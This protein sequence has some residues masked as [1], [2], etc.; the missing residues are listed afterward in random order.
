MGGV[1]NLSDALAWANTLV[2]AEFDNWRL[3]AAV[4]NPGGTGWV[5]YNMIGSELGHLYYTELGNAPALGGPAPPLNTGPFI[6]LHQDVF[7]SDGPGNPGGWMWAFNFSGGG[8]ALGYD[9]SEM[10]AWAVR[11]GDRSTLVSIDIK[12]GTSPN[13]INLGSNGSVAVAI[14]T[15]AEF[16]A[17]MVDP[18]TVEFADA[19]PFKRRMV[20]VDHDGNVDMLLY[21]YIQELNLDL[22]SILAT[23]TGMTDDDRVIVGTDSVEIVTKGKKK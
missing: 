19:P 3:P 9:L 17:S 16:D 14:L 22:N 7:W 21:F 10:G 15:T 23:L 13:T 8:Q 11:E 12:P 2:F 6:N 5:T 18:T 20:D 1:R 4:P